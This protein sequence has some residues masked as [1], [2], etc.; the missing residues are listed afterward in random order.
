MAADKE[1]RI[2]IVID[3]DGKAVATLNKIT[4][5][6]AK[7]R[8][9]LEDLDKTLKEMNGT[10]SMSEQEFKD[11][12]KMLKDLQKQVPINS[13]QYIQLGNSIKSLHGQ[14][15]ALKGGM[16][17]V[18]TATGSASASVLEMGRVISDS[19]Y[20]IRGVANNLSQLASNMVYTARSAGGLA[21]GLKSIWSAILGPLGILLAI[22]GLIALWERYD[23]KQDEVRRGLKET[24]GGIEEFDK[25][26][27][28]STATVEEAILKLETY[29]EAY[30]ESEAGTIK[31]TNALKELKDLGFDPTT[32]ALDDFIEKQKELIILEATAD[33][34]KKQLKTLVEARVE[35][36]ELIGKATKEYVK[37]QEALAK[38]GSP[39]LVAQN[40]G[41][42]EDAYTNLAKLTSERGN[43]FLNITDKA[44]EYKKLLNEL[45][46]LTTNNSET[47]SGSKGRNSV[48]A[49]KQELLNL[50]KEI[51]SYYKRTLTAT[52]YG[53][54]ELLKIK[55][56]Y[57]QKTLELKYVA[58][59][60][61]VE[62]NRTQNDENLKNEKIT[63]A[64]W[65]TNENTFQM[66]LLDS[67]FEYG[68]A[69]LEL[70]VAQ[71]TEKARIME[72]MALKEYLAVEKAKRGG[73]EAQGGSAVA[74]DSGVDKV[75]QEFALEQMRF[76][77]KMFF[78]A[79]EIKARQK[80]GKT[81]EDLTIKQANLVN[82]SEQDQYV[83]K[84]KLE[85]AKLD[86]VNQGLQFAI[87][88][89]GEGSAVGKAASVAMATI[90]T[91]EAANAALGAKPYGP[92]NIAQAAIVTAMGIANVNKIIN[93]KTPDGGGSGGSSPNISQDRTF[94][95]NL[96]GNTGVNQLA[97]GIGSQFDQPIQAYVVSSQ[98]TSQQQMDA[99]IQS[100]A[101]I[102]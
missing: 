33:V 76:D 38:S 63:Q 83:L 50:D 23:M 82:K 18:S 27:A 34:F 85:A 71:G 67:Q 6:V 96:V 65:Q 60:E 24:E 81:Y 11:Q 15:D 51:E 21:A 101:S 84:R 80:A 37:A 2:N 93:T 48:E 73:E 43:I 79:E 54:D 17:G 74:N 5:G 9:P 46:G 20:G 97:Q 32:Q 41:L 77:N 29:A 102:G 58:Y 42:L 1:F 12:L 98:M 92:W 66:A 62:L 90:S 86:V 100:N 7:L 88:V 95:F 14:Q 26:L 94:D 78:I 31:N 49:K 47:G 28:T 35:A 10:L 19:N 8:V 70:A 22:Q 61:K 40:L 91:Y 4:G 87:Q 56:D 55:Q 45:L 64:E 39:A 16:Q 75:N 69:S 25:T 72:E 52:E 99:T 3:K 89:A 44:A 59:Q 68:E 57:E 36:S 53:E 13:K 30:E